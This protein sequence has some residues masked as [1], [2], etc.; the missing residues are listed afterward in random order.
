MPRII[1]DE[2]TSNNSWDNQTYDLCNEA[3]GNDGRLGVRKLINL[4]PDMLE[5]HFHTDDQGRPYDP[6]NHPPYEE[7][8][9][10]CIITNKKL[11]NKDN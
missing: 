1:Y 5:E 7:T 11:T 9:Y 10:K 4:V 2:P 6:H 3:F 8:N